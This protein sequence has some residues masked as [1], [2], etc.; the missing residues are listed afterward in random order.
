MYSSNETLCVCC[1]KYVKRV[2]TSIYCRLRPWKWKPNLDLCTAVGMGEVLGRIFWHCNAKLSEAFSTNSCKRRLLAV[3]CFCL[4]TCRK[5]E[6]LNAW[7]KIVSY[8]SYRHVCNNL[9]SSS[10]RDKKGGRVQ[11]LLLRWGYH[12]NLVTPI[13][14]VT[15]E[16]LNLAFCVGEWRVFW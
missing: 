5:Q 9:V 10:F 16:V 6:T 11:V 13:L 15:C 14:T 1:S 4:S 7:T 8:K 2:I 12:N 3:P